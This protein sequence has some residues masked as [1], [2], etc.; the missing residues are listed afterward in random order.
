MYMLTTPAYWAVA[1]MI[2][3]RSGIDDRWKV[4]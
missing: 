1:I 3:G 4:R 2:F